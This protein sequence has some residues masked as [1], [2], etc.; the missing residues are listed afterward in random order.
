MNRN[1]Y[2]KLQDE[3]SAWTHENEPYQI[4]LKQFILLIRDNLPYIKPDKFLD[5]G[6]GD[7]WGI[8]E[9]K[10]YGFDVS[11]GDISEEKVKYAKEQGL[12]VEVMD[13]EDIKGKYTA[14][15]CSHTLEHSQDFKKAVDSMVGALK[16]GGRLYIVIPIEPKD[17]KKWNPSHTQYFSDKSVLRDYLM[18]KPVVIYWE[19]SRMRDI[20][21]YWLIVEKK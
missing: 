15:F 16:S 4:M 3:G 1:K 20:E 2:I 21:E 13:I 12:P 17:P 9:W 5:M 11:G 8:K 6:C 19:E 18:D 14:I 10:K 7:G